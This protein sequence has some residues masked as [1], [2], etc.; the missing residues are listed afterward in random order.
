MKFTMTITA[1]VAFTT[2]ATS[3][4]IPAAK[5]DGGSI[6]ITP[7][8]YYSSSVGVLGCKINTNRVA[9]WPMSP[10][11]DSMC[12]K[13]SANGR[14]VHLLQV[15]GSGGAYDIS[16][17]AWNYLKTGQSA[18][19]NP[20]AGGGFDANWERVDM[21][22]CADIIKPEANGKMAFM[23]ANSI[24]FV[25]GCAKGSWVGQNHAYYNIGDSTC[26]IGVDEVCT[27]NMA[28]SNQPSCPTS[29]LGSNAPLSGDRFMNILYPS[30]KEEVAVS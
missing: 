30:G 2:T 9:Y 18:K 4:A 19:T 16:Y 27:L 22:Q 3:F 8:D 5:R 10:S 1:L 13:V 24:N 29:V 28:V 15:D 12:V 21:S 23:A 26:E 20:V 25:E 14:D 11:C 6:S 17:D 7:H